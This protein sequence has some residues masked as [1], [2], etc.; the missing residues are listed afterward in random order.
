MRHFGVVPHLFGSRLNDAGRGGDI[1]LFVPED[2]PV[3][4]SV[5]RRCVSA[6]RSLNDLLAG[7]ALRDEG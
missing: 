5:P 2:W 4:E 1:D 3:E 7:H 6:R